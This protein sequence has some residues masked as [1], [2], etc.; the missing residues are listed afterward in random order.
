MGEKASLP[1]ERLGK[2]PVS[3]PCHS[4]DLEEFIYCVG[5]VGHRGMHPLDQL[6]YRTVPSRQVHIKSH[7]LEMRN[8]TSE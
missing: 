3:S 2:W 4:V 5:K 7:V 8:S 1:K 6:A